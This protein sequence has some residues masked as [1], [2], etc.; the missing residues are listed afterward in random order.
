MVTSDLKG[1]GDSG[2]PSLVIESRWPQ[3][4]ERMGG[5]HQGSLHCF[6]CL[7]CGT[8]VSEEGEVGGD[9]LLYSI[10]VPTSEQEPPMAPITG[11]G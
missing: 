7:A 1:K 4:A 2:T 9:L 10:Q 5:S 3:E 6:N 8:C 11:Y